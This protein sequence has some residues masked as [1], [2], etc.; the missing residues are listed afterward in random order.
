MQSETYVGDIEWEPVINYTSDGS[1]VYH[2]NFKASAEG[3]PETI[4]FTY[5]YFGL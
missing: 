1:Y 3:T 2:H 4:T 5:Q